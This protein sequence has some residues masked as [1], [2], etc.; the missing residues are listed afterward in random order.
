MNEEYCLTIQTGIEFSNLMLDPTVTTT[1]TSISEDDNHPVD[2]IKDGSPDTYW[3]S[4]LNSGKDT[5]TINLNTNRTA[6]RITIFWKYSPV[7]F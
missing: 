3:K 2:T 4:R 5:I 6:K 7:E 1:A